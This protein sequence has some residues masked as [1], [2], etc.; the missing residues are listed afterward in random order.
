MNWWSWGVLVGSSGLLGWA[1]VV[2]AGE[3]LGKTLPRARSTLGAR[4]SFGVP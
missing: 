3:V 4:E 2:E 1:F